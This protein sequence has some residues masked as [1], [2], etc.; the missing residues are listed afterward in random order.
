MTT[1]RA[2]RGTFVA[3][4][5]AVA[6]LSLLAACG[7]MGKPALSDSQWA[8]MDAALDQVVGPGGRSADSYNRHG[9]KFCGGPNSCSGADITKEWRLGRTD[10][11]AAV[12]ETARRSRLEGTQRQPDDPCY[13]NGSIDG[14]GV[15]IQIVP[16]DSDPATD[17][18]QVRLFEGTKFQ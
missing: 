11:C 7:L 3:T 1:A 6:L 13:V 4:P 2:R 8:E 18:L 10:S 17:C 15:S 5:L 9:G 12:E 14:F 16:C